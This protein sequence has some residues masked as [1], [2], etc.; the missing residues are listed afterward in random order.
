MTPFVPLNASMQITATVKTPNISMDNMAVGED[1]QTTRQFALESAPPAPVDITVTSNDG[2]I[3]LVSKDGT[4][5]GE[6]SV[7]FSVAKGTTSVDTVY[8]QGLKQGSTTLR[9]QADGYND[10]NPT[11]TVTGTST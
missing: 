10:A 4:L 6:T 5:V 7:T 2:T 9:V 1:L 3:A 11:V 8:V